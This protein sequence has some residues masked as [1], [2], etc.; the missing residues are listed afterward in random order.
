MNMQTQGQQAANE[1]SE[2][3]TTYLVIDQEQVVYRT[4]RLGEAIAFLLGSKTGVLCQV[5][6]Q[7]G[8][9]TR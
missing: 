9:N 4:G 7:P 2:P 5:L 3:S 6:S 1:P 8:D